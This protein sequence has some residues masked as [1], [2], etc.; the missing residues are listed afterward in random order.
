MNELTIEMSMFMNSKDYLGTKL[1]D[2][3][4]TFMKNNLWSLQGN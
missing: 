2:R 1:M 4:Q 3:Y